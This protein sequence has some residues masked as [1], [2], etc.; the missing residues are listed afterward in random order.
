MGFISQHFEKYADF[1][2][3]PWPQRPLLTIL[4][5]MEAVGIRATQLVV[6]RVVRRLHESG[7]FHDRKSPPVYL[8]PFAEACY[9][10]RGK[11]EAA[12]TTDLQVVDAPR[13]CNSHCLPGARVC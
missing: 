7:A 12:H 4:R 2:A 6:L 11:L 8:L 5:D 10:C 3:Q 13:V 1:F 9:A